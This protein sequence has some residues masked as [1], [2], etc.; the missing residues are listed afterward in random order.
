MAKQN[1]VFKVD[2]SMELMKFL[3]E[4]MPENSRNSI[5]SMLTHKRVLVDDEV[6]SQ[7]NY[8]LKA[9]QTVSIGKAKISKQDL[10]GV[11]ILYEDKDIIVIEKA[12]GLLSVATAKEK[13]N[14]AYSILKKY[15]KEKDPKNMIFVVH[16]LDRDTSGV[17]LFAKTAKAQDILQTNWNDMVK[18]RTYVAVV[19]GTMEKDS[20][21][22]TSYLAENKAYITY[23]TDNK[24]EGKKAISTYKVLKK[25]KR[26]S[27]VEVNIE[28]GR[29]NQIRVHMQELGHSVI[30]DKKYGAT[31]NP[32]KRLGLHA[33]SIV[34]THPITKE[35]FSFTSEI[36]N[37]FNSLFR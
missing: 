30:G 33:H 21:T 5:K 27:M 8:L 15:L 9:G 35:V 6:V 19:E 12:K 16:R 23:S 4:K 17:M 31:T 14:T 37:E 10:K 28:T 20:D 34:F 3:M 22:I 13:D 7:Y 24:E 36:P 26:Y 11:T 32:I 18:E 1:T 2:N 25:N 29:K